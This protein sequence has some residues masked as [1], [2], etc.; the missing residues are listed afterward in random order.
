MT[1]QEYELMRDLQNVRTANKL[2]QQVNLEDYIDKQDAL[3]AKY[4]LSRAESDLLAKVDEALG[5]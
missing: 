5:D 3:D 1:A 2:L 4:A